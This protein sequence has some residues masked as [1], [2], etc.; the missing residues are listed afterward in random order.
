VVGFGKLRGEANGYCGAF[1]VALER[2]RHLFVG[3]QVRIAEEG[4]SEVRGN[5]QTVFGWRTKIKRLD[6]EDEANFE[7]RD[8][9]IFRSWR[10]RR[11]AVGWTS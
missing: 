2:G 9:L 10:G 1:G 5:G 11:S 8:Q 3:K 7:K 6:L 4:E